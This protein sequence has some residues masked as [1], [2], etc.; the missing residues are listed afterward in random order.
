M[1]EG[2]PLC[3]VDLKVTAKD[4]QGQIGNVKVVSSMDWFSTQH[5]RNSKATCEREIILEVARSRFKSSLTCNFQLRDSKVQMWID[6][7]SNCLHF[8][9][10]ILA[11]D[12]LLFKL[13]SSS[14]Q[15]FGVTERNAVRYHKVSK[16]AHQMSINDS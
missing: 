12:A 14:V 5:M 6:Q 13:F 7:K 15:P 10:F 2:L 11:L 9:A 1:G 16:V 8:T 3:K 4:Q